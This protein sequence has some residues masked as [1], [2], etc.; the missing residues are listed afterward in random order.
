MAMASFGALIH[1]LNIIAAAWFAQKAFKRLFKE[2]ELASSR[3]DATCA[4]NAESMEMPA[5]QPL[6]N[7][8][9]EAFAQRIAA[10]AS[11]TAAYAHPY[12]RP[13]DN[14]AAVRGGKLIRNVNIR[15]RAMALEA[16]SAR[17]WRRLRWRP[18]R[19]YRSQDARSWRR[20]CKR[21]KSRAQR[22]C[23]T[24]VVIAGERH[25]D[26]FKI[27]AEL[28]R[29]RNCHGCVTRNRFDRRPGLCE[30]KKI[31]AMGHRDS[32]KNAAKSKADDA[33]QRG[34]CHKDHRTPRP[35]HDRKTNGPDHAPW[36]MFGVIQ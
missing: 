35:K 4:A 36:S 7:L 14:V 12:G 16:E 10:G 29:D 17:F 11:A 31:S 27:R 28:K 21:I 25:A 24:T 32:A 18:E 2:V 5:S 20:P 33:G 23:R 22:R 30:D 13:R 34:V 3:E 8:R 15:E 1:I 9:H 6:K 26:C 19:R